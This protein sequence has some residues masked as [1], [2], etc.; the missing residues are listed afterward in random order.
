MAFSNRI[1]WRMN[2]I[3]F[4]S[5]VKF[6]ISFKFIYKETNYVPNFLCLDNQIKF[7]CSTCSIYKIL[8]F[9]FNKP[10]Y[11]FYCVLQ[12]FYIDKVCICC[13]KEGG[14]GWT[15]WENLINI[16]L[17]QNRSYCKSVENCHWTLWISILKIQLNNR[18][19]F[20]NLLLL[21]VRFSD[22]R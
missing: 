21:V 1:L 19:W 3:G 15:V 22:L 18:N 13:S 16:Y 8:K 4:M 2:K 20:W 17:S 10:L 14:S 11:W 12:S 9:K 7:S 5:V 6:H